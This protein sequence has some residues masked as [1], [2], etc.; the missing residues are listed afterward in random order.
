MNNDL[1]CLVRP[2]AILQVTDYEGGVYHVYDHT[3]SSVKQEKLI[4]KLYINH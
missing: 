2:I 1:R 3:D 4:I